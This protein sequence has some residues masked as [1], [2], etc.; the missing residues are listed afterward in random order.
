MLK[1]PGTW[2]VL[3]KMQTHTGHISEL[4]RKHKDPGAGGYY[5]VVRWGH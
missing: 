5:Q 4:L 3:N 1:V 2:Q